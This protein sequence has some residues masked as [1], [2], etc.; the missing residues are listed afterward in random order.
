MIH[1][2]GSPRFHPLL[3]ARTCLLITAAGLSTVSLVA[4]VPSFGSIDAPDAGTHRN[5]GTVATSINGFNF[6]TGWYIDNA[7]ARHGFLR[8]NGG[9]ITEFDPPSMTETFPTA[10]NGSFQILGYASRTGGGRTHEHGFLRSRFGQYDA[11]DVPG[12]VDTLPYAMNDSGQIAGGYDDS[13]GR[14]HGFLRD[15]N[16]NYT[17]LNVPDQGTNTTLATTA[18]AI[19]ANG[20]ITG[21]YADSLGVNHGFVRDPSG[22][23][24]SFD[25]PGAG[26]SGTF[27]DSING[28]GAITG[29][30]SDDNFVAHSF[31]RDASGNLVSFDVP[32][33]NQTFAESINDSGTI[34]GQVSKGTGFAAFRRDS[35]GNFGLLSVPVENAGSSAANITGN[36]I[37]GYYVDVNGVSHGF[38]TRVLTR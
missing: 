21:Y 8:Q 23:Y 18:K 17:I 10:I 34:V 26:G 38:T 37:T 3:L 24:V 11:V 27:P 2:S 6:I 14:L 36:R 20:L 22:N 31:V 1:T 4:Q 30:Y 28:S 35:L 25:A 13:V 9:A 5:Q 32:G 7:G 16:G 12:A 29:S 19:N 15:T 33:A